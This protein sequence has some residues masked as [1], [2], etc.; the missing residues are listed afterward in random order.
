[1]NKE[2]LKNNRVVRHC[3]YFVIAILKSRKLKKSAERTLDSFGLLFS[4]E[5]DKKTCVKDMVRT[6]ARHGF[7]FDE[8]CYYD[9]M[10]KTKRERLA[11]VADWEHLGYTCAMNDPRNADLYDNKWKTYLKYRDFYCR[12]VAYI[13]AENKHEFDAFIE[14]HQKA[15]V[16]PLD[17]SCGRGVQIVDRTNASVDELL[18]ACNGRFI[19]E[20]LIVQ[21]PEMAKFHPSSV[22][23]VRVPTIKMQDD[24]LIVHPF[25]R[26]GQH[27]S[28]VDNAGAGGIICAID[29]SCGRVLAAADEHGHQYTEHP[30]TK[31]AIVG[32][33]IP[34]WDELVGF[35]KRAA[36]VVPEN[37]YT[38]WDLALTDEGWILIEANRRGQFVWQIPLQSGFRDE[39]N[40]IL[41]K[42]GTKY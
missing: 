28:F 1:M 13:D 6:Y 32:F 7:G 33:Q 5:T 2:K 21:A 35:V 14:E 34:R 41:K 19:V 15:I 3:Y 40:G 20:E 39:I 17:L 24:V 25:M 37:R 31:E 22:N 27:G 10:H 29:A 8:Y 18:I 12:K 9:F 4:S 30:D 38:G 11:F 42:L 26:M 36:L 23:T 16:K